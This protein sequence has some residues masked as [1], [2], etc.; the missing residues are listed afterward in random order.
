MIFWPCPQPLPDTFGLSPSWSLCGCNEPYCEDCKVGRCTT[1]CGQ[2]DFR[3]VDGQLSISN[4]VRSAVL[5]S[6]MMHKRIE[7]ETELNY[8]LGQCEQKGGWWAE[9]MI[10]REFGIT[11]WTLEYTRPTA[12]AEVIVE[13]SLT[14]SISYLVDQGL[15]EDV[16]IEAELDLC[17]G[18]VCVSNLE[19]RRPQDDPQ[20]THFDLM[21]GTEIC[22]AC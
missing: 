10:G 14:E 1:T 22:E 16:D 18:T 12:V 5:F 2:L 11:H 20:K 19:V 9:E 8:P 3:I 13:R 4:Q 7:D 17:T 21:W 15:I 6:I